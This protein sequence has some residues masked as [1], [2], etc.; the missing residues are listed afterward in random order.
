MNK[1]NRG[2]ERPQTTPVPTSMYD[3]KRL[4][5]FEERRPLTQRER[6]ELLMDNLLRGIEKKEESKVVAKRGRYTAPSCD[7]PSVW[8]TSDRN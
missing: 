2:D 1:R 8:G 7:K 3:R 4:P 5:Y 6:R